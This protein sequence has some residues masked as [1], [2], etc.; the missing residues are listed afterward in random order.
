MPS[1]IVAARSPNIEGVSGKERFVFRAADA[2]EPFER[3]RRMTRDLGCDIIGGKAGARSGM[4]QDVRKLAP[5][6]LG[7]GWYGGEARVPGAEHQ[8]DIFRAILGGDGDAIAGSQ[9]E[10]LAQ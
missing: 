6:Q 10:P 9:R 4:V 8:L 1:Q 3:R 7:I 5:M 2:D